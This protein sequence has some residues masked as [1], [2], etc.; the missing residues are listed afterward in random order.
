LYVIVYQ[1]DLTGLWGLQR[2]QRSV[3]IVAGM[4][5]DAALLG[6]LLLTERFVLTDSGSITLAVVRALILLKI[7]NLLFQ[8]E[9]FMRTDVYALYALATRSRNLWATKGAVARNLLHRATPLDRRL[10]ASTSRREIR[11]AMLYLLLYVPGVAWATW[12][13]VAFGLPSIARIAELSLAAITDDGLLSIAGIGGAASLL[14]CFGP[15]G[16]TL[17]GVGRNAVRGAR[18]LLRPTRRK[19]IREVPGEPPSG[20]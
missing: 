7:T 19:R 6:L 14:L 18:Q 5:A 10:L 8:I 13:L 12:Y 9:I 20:R 4:T 16:W 15:L 11:W 17:F 1:T 3:P 2:R